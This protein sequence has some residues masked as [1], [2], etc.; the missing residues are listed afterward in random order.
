M[1]ACAILSQFPVVSGYSVVLNNGMERFPVGTLGKYLIR[2]IIS[3]GQ[4]RHP[5]KVTRGASLRAIAWIG[6]LSVAIALLLWPGSAQAEDYTKQNLVDS[7]FSHR[8]LTDSSF[9]KANL[10]NSDLSYS[11]LRGVSFFGAN[12]ES[13]NLEGADLSYATLDTARLVRS[14]LTNAVLEG[15][16]AFNTKFD[17][18]TI[19]GAD[20]TDVLLR[21]DVQRQL[22]DIA[23]G[24]NPTTGRDTRESLGC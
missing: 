17:G 22:C 13:T 8:V 23:A 20:F 4:W 15:A 2:P 10:R 9:T 1:A 19:D 5:A 16:F 14:T 7:D 3:T 24:T 11:D 18:A 21:G 6:L 12:L